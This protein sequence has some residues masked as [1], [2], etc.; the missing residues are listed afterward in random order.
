MPLIAM[1]ICTNSFRDNNRLLPT[2]IY[3]QAK[4]PH[5]K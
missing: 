3:Y 5:K 2:S 4:E 1:N